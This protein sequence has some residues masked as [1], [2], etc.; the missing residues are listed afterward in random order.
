ML[1]TIHTI[2]ANLWEMEVEK[3]KS[4]YDII[5]QSKST[6]VQDGRVSLS[7]VISLTF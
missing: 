5:S 1:S 6:T 2:I 7:L 3:H 4:K